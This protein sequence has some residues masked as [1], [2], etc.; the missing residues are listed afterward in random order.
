M[1]QR[2]K[3][4]RLQCRYQADD[5][6]KPDALMRLAGKTVAFVTHLQPVNSPSDVCDQVTINFTDGSFVTFT[7][8][9][10]FSPQQALGFVIEDRGGD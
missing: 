8:D 2:N 5:N 10:A 1:S 9:I 6:A 4:E 3:V 7:Q